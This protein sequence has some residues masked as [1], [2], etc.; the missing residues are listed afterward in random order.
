[1]LSKADSRKMG[2]LKCRCLPSVSLS[3]QGYQPFAR[4]HLKACDLINEWDCSVLGTNT[5]D[6]LPEQ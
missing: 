1:M 3:A 2:E 5:C 4:L 6:S